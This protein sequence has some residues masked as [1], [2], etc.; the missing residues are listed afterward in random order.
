MMALSGW[1]APAMA[2]RARQALRLSRAARA[3][4]RVSRRR[5]RLKSLSKR[6]KPGAISTPGFRQ[7]PRAKGSG[8]I[9]LVAKGRI[10]LP[11]QGFSV[12]CSTN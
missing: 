8:V 4:R 2:R 1:R 12:L 5:Q 7:A 3:R 10:E 9:G 6:K 11:T